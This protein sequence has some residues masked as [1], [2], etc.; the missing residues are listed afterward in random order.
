MTAPRKFAEK[1]ALLNQKEAEQNAAF[2]NIMDEVNSIVILN[3]L[4]YFD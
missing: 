1:I 3:Y 4:S 2:K